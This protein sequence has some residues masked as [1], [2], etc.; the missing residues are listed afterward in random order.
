MSDYLD[1][2][3]HAEALQIKEAIQS[4]EKKTSGEIRVHI[5][6]YCNH[7]VMDRATQVFNKLKMSDTKERNGVLFYISVKD[8]DFAVIGDEG[9]HAKVIDG[10]W[11]DLCREMEKFFRSAHFVEGL[12]QAIHKA[13][14]SL[15]TYFPF[16][17]DDANELSDDI[18][19]GHI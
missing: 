4:A 2:F 14:D 6:D 5:E 16:Q 12:V 8:R 11:E 1:F 3:T 9:I 13:A 18:S 15:A 7:L 17:L 19:V 10:Y